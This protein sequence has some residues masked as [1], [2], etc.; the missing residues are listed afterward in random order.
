[1]KENPPTYVLTRKGFTG[2]GYLPEEPGLEDSLK[3]KERTVVCGGVTWPVDVSVELGWA[4]NQNTVCL[5]N[6]P[7]NFLPEICV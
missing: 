2:D 6:K 1:M 3:E 4:G 7:R 5:R